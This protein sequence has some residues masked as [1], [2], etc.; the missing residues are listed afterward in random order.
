VGNVMLQNVVCRISFDVICNYRLI[1]DWFVKLNYGLCTT[2]ISS[3][4]A[5]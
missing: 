5:L 4:V 2:W 1:C 3:F